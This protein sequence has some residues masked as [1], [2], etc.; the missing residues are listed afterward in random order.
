MDPYRVHFAQR[1]KSLGAIPSGVPDGNIEAIW[2]V[3]W[4]T[5]HEMRTRLSGLPPGNFEVN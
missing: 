2:K 5:R 3:A 4:G 1:P